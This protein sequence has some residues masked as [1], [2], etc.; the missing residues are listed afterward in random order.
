[1]RVL[2][3][4]TDAFGGVGGIS[5]CNRNLLSALCSHPACEEVVAIPRLMPHQCEELPAK[6]TYVTNGINSKARY[7]VAVL[8][9]LLGFRRFDLILC[10][11]INL[12]PIACLLKGLLHAPVLLVIH[13]IDAW[14]PTGS[15]IVNLL[16]NKI[17][18]FI[19]VSEVTK[20]RFLRWADL[21]EGKG[22]VL[23]N[24]FHVERYGP[25]PK[26]PGLLARYG[27]DGRTILMTV[28]RLSSFEKYKGID[29]VIELLPD[30]AG[31]VPNVSYLIVGDGSDRKR[32]EEKAASLGVSDRVVFAGYVS[33]EE[34]ADHYRLADA[35]VMP[36]SGEGFGIVFLEAMACGIPVV[37]SK[38]DGSREAVR[39]GEL[40]IIVD[41]ADRGEIMAAILKT[42]ME[43]K[44]RVPEGL[45]FFSYENFSRRLHG[46]ID[47]MGI[48]GG[49]RD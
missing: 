49:R 6:L 1:M 27:L 20:R 45:S 37:A 34:K 25:G 24:T 3:L 11:H 26:R 30:L 12:V 42:L 22:F 44:G 19:S 8:R 4:L 28:G 43:K 10:G 21:P 48:N 2:V 13:G 38:V 47:E 35:Y 9:T 40:G 16:V 23:P 33:E 15:R 5:L 46:I 32:L 18:M 39:D 17:D 31:K 7:I 36:S 14:T 41:P 29:E